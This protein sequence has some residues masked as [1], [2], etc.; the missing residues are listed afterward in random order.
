M[1]NSGCRRCNIAETTEYELYSA[2][3]STAGRTPWTGGVSRLQTTYRGTVNRCAGNYNR[4]RH[5]KHHRRRCTVETGRAGLSAGP[6]NSTADQC[7]TGPVNG[8]VAGSQTAYRNTVNRYAGNY[9]RIRHTKR[10]R[11]ILF[12][13][14][15]MFFCNTNTG[16]TE[17]AC[18]NEINYRFP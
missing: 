16:S 12:R 13:N 15:L 5:T 17:P 6:L 7:Q 1:Y 9:N 11:L 2:P 10:H 3:Q 8:G 4:I 14:I 18:K